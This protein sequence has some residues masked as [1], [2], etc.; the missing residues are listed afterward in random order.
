MSQYRGM[1]FVMLNNAEWHLPDECG[2]YTMREL[3]GSLLPMPDSAK[4]DRRV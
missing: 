2:W 3:S 1:L 4:Y